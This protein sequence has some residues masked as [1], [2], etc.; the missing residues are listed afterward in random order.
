MFV[1]SAKFT[2]TNRSGVQLAARLER[3]GGEPRAYALFAH[4]FTCSKDTVAAARISQELAA[5]G[6]AVLRFD[7]TGLGGSEGEFANTDFSSNLD[8]LEDA[9][10]HLREVYQAPRILIGHSLG[11]AAT[12]AVAGRIP[13]A[14]AVA[15]IAAPADPAHVRHLFGEKEQAIW[16]HGEAEVQLA[17]RGFRIRREFLEDIQGQRLEEAITRL[18]RPLLIF[19][20]PRDQLVG[21]ENASAIFTAATH[22]KSFISLDDADHLLSRREDARYVAKVLVAWASRYLS[23]DARAESGPPEGT[24][25]VAETGAGRFAQVVRAGRHVLC[26][27]EPASVG[28]DDSGPGPYDY[29]LA[30]LG[31][32]SSMTLRMYVERKGWPLERVVVRLRHG[33]IHAKDCEDCE[34][35]EGKVD[36][37]E[38]EIELQGALDDEQR[39]RLL[40][41]AERCPVHQTLTSETKIVTRA[42]EG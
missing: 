1:S 37:I 34:T 29:L 7:F 28:G 39:R 25:E 35:K 38:R 41:I 27:D 4:C 9:A 18:K 15:T 33:R 36:R 32:C 30:G 16:E 40:E 3:P 10:A 17:G 21:I 42:A 20:G 26:A 6:I 22:P 14:V 24:V 13:E 11:G 31:S 5:H 12:L 2:F 23:A 19:H 8:D